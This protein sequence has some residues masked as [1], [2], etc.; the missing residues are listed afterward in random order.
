MW[1]FDQGGKAQ[2]G[3]RATRP[4]NTHYGKEQTIPTITKR[5]WSVTKGVH[6][7]TK[8]VVTGNSV[9]KKAD[10]K[11]KPPTAQLSIPQEGKMGLGDVCARGK[12]VGVAGNNTVHS[13]EQGALQDYIRPPGSTPE[14]SWGR[15]G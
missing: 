7:F 1:S 4:F 2:K 5:R 6:F 10:T 12:M 15:V 8:K 9:Q 14:H 3:R 11:G 13:A